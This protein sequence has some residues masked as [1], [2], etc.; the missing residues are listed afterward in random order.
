MRSVPYATVGMDA[1]LLAGTTFTDGAQTY[2]Y[3]TGG[4]TAPAA[5]Q[6]V[7]GTVLTIQRAIVWAAVGSNAQAYKRAIAIV[8]WTDTSGSHSVRQDSYVYPGGLGPAN[9]TTTTSTTSTTLASTPGAPTA[10]TATTDAVY[11]T[12]AIDL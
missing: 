1:S 10:L 4:H 3:V 7:S 9:S 5:T 8:R 12:S 6:N 2:T 11:P